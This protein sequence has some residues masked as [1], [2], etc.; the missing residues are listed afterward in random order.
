MADIY[1][2]RSDNLGPKGPIFHF[3]QVRA[4]GMP[5]SGVIAVL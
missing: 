4:A 1:E 3:D 5:C 2:E